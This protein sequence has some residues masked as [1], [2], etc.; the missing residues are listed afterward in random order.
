MTVGMIRFRTNL[1]AQVSFLLREVVSRLNELKPILNE[2][3]STDDHP[4]SSPAVAVL[5][6]RTSRDRVHFKI[7]LS[8][9]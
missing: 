1:K 2:A 5:Q 9:E 4:A 7:K 8:G 3:F 6:R